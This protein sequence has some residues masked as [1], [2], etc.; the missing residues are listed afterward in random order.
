MAIYTFY[1]CNADGSSYSLEAFDLG[2]DAE[3]A[4]RASQMLA[5][6]GRCAYVAVW[7]GDRPVRACHR[8]APEGGASHDRPTSAYAEG[9]MRSGGIA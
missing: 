8:A 9:T 4:P 6:H 7:Q 2:G 3:T 5:E 1:L